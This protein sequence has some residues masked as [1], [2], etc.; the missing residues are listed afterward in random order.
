[1]EWN[2]RAESLGGSGVTGPAPSRAA[3]HLGSWRSISRPQAGSGEQ[4]WLG[5]PTTCLSTP[6]LGWGGA[7][8]GSYSALGVCAGG[9]R[10]L[11]SRK[12]SRNSPEHTVKQTRAPASQYTAERQARVTGP[13][14]N[15]P[16]RLSLGPGNAGLSCIKWLEQEGWKQTAEGSQEGLVWSLLGAGSP[17][18]QAWPPRAHKE[19]QALPQRPHL[20]QPPWAPRPWPGHPGSAVCP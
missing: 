3:A 2:T 10:F 14:G 16:A 19:P 4:S 12:G 15:P 11:R 13:L 9:L 6:S 18:T 17:P 7:G 8:P 20:R 1:M 5:P